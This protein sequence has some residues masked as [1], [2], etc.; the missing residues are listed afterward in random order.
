MNEIY[1]MK[2]SMIQF[3]ITLIQNNLKFI[4][5]NEEHK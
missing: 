3:P 2:N 1:G 4:L 5:R